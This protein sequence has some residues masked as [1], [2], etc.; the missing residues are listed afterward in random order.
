MIV[1]C[2]RC[3]EPL[4]ENLPYCPICR[5][6]QVREAWAVRIDPVLWGVVRESLLVRFRRYGALSV[7]ALVGVL[8]LFPVAPIGGVVAGSA[9]LIQIARGRAKREGAPLAI[10]GLVAGA[11]W[12]T[13]A[14]YFASHALG[15]IHG[16][17]SWL[18]LPGPWRPVD[19]PIQEVLAFGVAPDRRTPQ[20]WA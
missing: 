10:V 20:M 2:V 1:E 9:A 17:P 3:G 16:L 18:W 5:S 11:L 6:P 14:I 4:S 7:V 15:M 13:V 19:S 12:L 8:P